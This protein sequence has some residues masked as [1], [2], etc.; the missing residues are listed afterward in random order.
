MTKVDFDSV[1]SRFT[2]SLMQ[3][4]VGRATPSMVEGL[5]VEAYGSMMG[6]QEVAGITAPE[7]Q[8]LV[9]QPWDQSLLQAIEAA[10]RTS[11]LGLNPVVDGEI[12]RINIPP[13]TEEKRKDLVKLMHE[14][15]EEARIAIRR[16]REEALKKYKA[17]QKEGRISEDDYF[18]EEK[19]IQD[20]VD[21]A[22][23]SVKS[24]SEAKENDLMKV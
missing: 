11:D 24:I 14:R 13:M 1:I 5:Q 17:E 9:I 3:I 18:R 19:A 15:A 20:L 7:P 8:M 16:L 23:E 12:V 4:H 2:D 10:V 22:N 21:A 6:M